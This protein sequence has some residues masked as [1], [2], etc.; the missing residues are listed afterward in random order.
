M[1]IKT[2]LVPMQTE[3]AATDALG[4]GNCFGGKAERPCC[5]S[6]YQAT[7]DTGCALGI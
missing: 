5:R 7:S 1:A 3:G 2:I 4:A 6:S